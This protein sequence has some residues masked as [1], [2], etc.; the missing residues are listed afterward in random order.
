MQKIGLN[1]AGNYSG[2]FWTYNFSICLLENP[3]NLISMN[4]GFS[5]VSPS[6]K[7]NIIY[8]GRPPGYLNWSKKQSQIISKKQDFINL[9]N[10]TSKHIFLWKDGHRSIPTIRR[11]ASWKSWIWDQYLPENK[12]SK[13]DKSLKLWDKETKTP[14]ATM[15]FLEIINQAPSN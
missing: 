4:S 10:S 6:P 8:L 13:F 12:E 5:D 11:I 2:P 9:K 3:G 1:N 14:K 7:A 15:N